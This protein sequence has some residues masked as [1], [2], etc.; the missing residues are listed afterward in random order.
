MSSVTHM[1][2]VIRGLRR[3]Q[4]ARYLNLASLLVLVTLFGLAALEILVGS[5]WSISFFVVFAAHL[6][7]AAY[8]GFTKCPNCHR[9]FS[10]RTI[11]AFVSSLE[12]QLTTECQNCHISLAKAVAMP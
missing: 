12:D 8:L 2:N 6:I 11:L 5:A 9:R 7:A 1:S 10:R 3:R 4:W